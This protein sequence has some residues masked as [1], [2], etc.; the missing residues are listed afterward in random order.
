MAYVSNLSHRL[1]QDGPANSKSLKRVFWCPYIPDDLESKVDDCDDGYL[2]A[3][4]RDCKVSCLLHTMTILGFI[5]DP[6]LWQC[7]RS[8]LV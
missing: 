2:L 5:G 3:V 4:I 7:N 8:S 6:Y 1:F